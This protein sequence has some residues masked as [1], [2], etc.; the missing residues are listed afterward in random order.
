MLV[1]LGEQG[2]VQI[3]EELR[4]GLDELSL[5]EAVRRE[6]G[7]IELRPHG[8]IDPDQAWFWTEAWQR[9]ERQADADIAAGRV[10][11]FDDLESLLA[12]LDADDEEDLR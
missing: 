2:T 11:R 6:D 9:G 12:D 7:V 5:V 8:K 3:P 4:D 1:K 10:E